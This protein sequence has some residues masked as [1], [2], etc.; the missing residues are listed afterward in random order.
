MKQFA[1]T[2][3]LD[4]FGT[5]PQKPKERN[6]LG[7]YLLMRHIDSNEGFSVPLKS[8]PVTDTRQDETKTKFMETLEQFG[9]LEPYNKEWSNTIYY[10]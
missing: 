1:L 8:F 7:I 2:V 9:L 4:H 10:F 6:I 3:A 5:D